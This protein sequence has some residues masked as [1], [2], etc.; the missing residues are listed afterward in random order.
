MSN[1]APSPA[2]HTLSSEAELAETLERIGSA[3]M[4]DLVLERIV[5][6]VTDEATRL[7]GAQFGAFFYNTVNEAGESLMLYALSGAPREAFAGFP[8][9]R[10]TQVFEPTF[11]G[12]AVVRSD[13]ITQDPRYGKNA[14]H[15]GMPAGHLPVVSYLSV[16][17]RSRSGEVLGGLF[18]GHERRAVFTE[19]HERLTIGIASWAALAIDNARL[20]DAER[21]ARAAAERSA[22]ALA[23]ANAQLEAQTRQAA[24]GTQQLREQTAALESQAEELRRAGSQLQESERQFGTLAEAI[25]Q[26]A[27]IAESD[28]YISWYNQRWY[29]YTGTTP[30]QMAGWGWQSVHDPEMLPDVVERW[31]RSI[32]TGTPFDME[33]PLRGADGR[34]RWFLTR[35]TPVTDAEGSVTR[36][37]GTNTDVDA[38][39]EARADAEQA[40]QAKSEFLATMSHELRTPLNA[41]TGYVDLLAM[42][43]HGPI[44]PPQREALRRV[45]RSAHKLMTLINDLL[46]FARIDAGHVEFRVEDV[47][48]GEAMTEVFDIIAPQLPASGIR[49]IDRGVLAP[50]GRAVIVRADRDR[51]EQVLLNLV[52]NAIKFTAPGGTIEVSGEALEDVVH[53]RVRDTGIGIPA[54]RLA[55]V[56]EPFVQVDA[57]HTRTSGGV[58][59]GLS[60]SRDLARG[61]SGELTAESTVGEGST[62]TITLPRALGG[63]RRADASDGE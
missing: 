20:F 27:W 2:A 37:F 61:M 30:E 18:F 52:S 32:A 40:N 44:A 57:R 19:L 63:R 4:A 25:P 26:L 59:L 35:V 23:K 13:D 5:Q 1:V 46:E 8:M 51:L 12:T 24:A 39:R 53:I 56:F 22:Q 48:L 14:P 58:G 33:F 43:I 15:Y 7:T 31:R 50:D 6:I 21:H 16:P 49:F 9:P 3:V 55:S 29:D 36:W 41:I 54:E 45:T 47:A 60:I 28:G 34:F 17:V 42:E 11:R 10:N 38:L 62:F